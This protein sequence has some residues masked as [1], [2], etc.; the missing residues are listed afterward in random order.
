MF[1]LV[2]VCKAIDVTNSRNVKS[3]LDPEDVQQINTLTAGGNQQL[4]YISESGLYDTIIRSDSPKAKPFRKWVTKEVLPSIRKT[5]G[6]IIATPEDTPEVIIARG[7]V[8]AKEALDRMTER[9]LSAE[10]NLQIAA[11]KAEYYDAV[12]TDRELFT[13]TQ[14]ACELGM[15][16]KTLRTKLVQ[17]NIVTSNTGL[18]I[19]LPEYEN[20]GEHES[21]TGRKGRSDFKWNRVGRDA[22]F[23][24]ID[25]NMPK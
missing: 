6:Y 14:I 11:P 15:C 4:T 7:M 16:Y 17:A 1:C 13:T 10:S 24:L 19:V 5:G 22:I 12:V 3:R 25:P 21:R 9:A 2:D 18:L 23:N 20:W 8:A